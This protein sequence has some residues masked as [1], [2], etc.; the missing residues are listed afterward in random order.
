MFVS[1]KDDEGGIIWDIAPVEVLMDVCDK[2]GNSLLTPDTPG[3]VVGE[4]MTI[5]YEGKT[6]PIQWQTDIPQP[7]RA[8]LAVFNGMWHHRLNSYN[9]SLD[10]NIWTIRIGELPGDETRDYTLP[11]TFRG[12]THTLHISRKWYGVKNKK[13]KTVITFDGKR[14]DGYTVRLIAD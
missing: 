9:P 14:V 10:Q 7:S 6:Y 5:Q 2:D 11:I 13:N 12:K 8:Y 3:S 4:E 1:C